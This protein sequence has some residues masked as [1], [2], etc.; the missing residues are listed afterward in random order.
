[1]ARRAASHPWQEALTSHLCWPNHKHTRLA[2]STFQRQDLD[3]G[4][5]GGSDICQTDH[6]IGDTTPSMWNW[7]EDQMEGLPSVK[8]M[9]AY[10][11]NLLA[12]H[13]DSSNVRMSPLQTGPF[14]LCMVE[15]LLSSKNSMQT[16]VPL[17]QCQIHLPYW[18]SHK[19]HGTVKHYTSRKSKNKITSSFVPYI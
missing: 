6:H 17:S 3:G 9:H 4:S 12:S 15:Q 16:N 7:M 1:M 5:E 19:W 18:P 10:H 2:G 14:M 11:F 8:P 13:P